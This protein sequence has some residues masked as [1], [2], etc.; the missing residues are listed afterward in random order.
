MTRESRARWLAFATAA[1]VVL[2][3]A[4]FAGLR[5]LYPVQVP[6]VEKA[7]AAAAAATADG[8][9]A[10]RAAFVDLGCATCHAAERKG[11][12]GLP[13]DG[14]GRRL[15]RNELRAAALG[16]GATADTLPAGIVQAKRR[17]RDGPAIEALLDYLQQLR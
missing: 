2:L 16:L 15:D 3:A 8:M 9:A 5:N 17:Q 1:L 4:L 11:N 6:D 10:G 14:I 13:L 12:P 7:P